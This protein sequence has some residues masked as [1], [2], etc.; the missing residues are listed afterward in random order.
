HHLADKA[1]DHFAASAG[2]KAS[3]KMLRGVSKTVRKATGLLTGEAMDGKQRD[4]IS[5][6]EKAIK[7]VEETDNWVASEFPMPEQKRWAREHAVWR[8]E[9]GRAPEHLV[10]LSKAGKSEA[11]RLYEA[12]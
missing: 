2:L 8:F 10:E 7:I 1:L 5:A 3:K 12:L 4:A 9:R 6:A 11:L